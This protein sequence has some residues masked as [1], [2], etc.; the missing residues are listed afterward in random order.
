MPNPNQR[1]GREWEESCARLLRETAGFTDAERTVVRHPDRGDIGGVPD[2]TLECK[3]VGPRPGVPTT[4]QGAFGAWAPDGS[5]AGPRVA[6]AAGWRAAQAAAPR[7]DMAAALDQLSKAQAT[8]G[9]PYGAVI[10][11]RRN[12]GPD[13]GFMIVEFGMGAGLMRRLAEEG[14]P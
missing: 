12:H 7:F 6:F 11:K 10:R 14:S 8:N 4:V 9:T 2:W 5:G 3:G 1:A 13:R